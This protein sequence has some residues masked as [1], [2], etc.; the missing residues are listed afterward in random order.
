MEEMENEYEKGIYWVVFFLIIFFAAFLGYEFVFNNSNNKEKEKYKEVIEVQDYD[1]YLGV[2]QLFGD[3]DVPEYELSVEIID[4]ATVTFDFAVKDVVSFESETATFEDDIA[5]FELED[6]NEDKISGRLAFK[7]EKV[8][9]TITSSSFD[10]ITV[11]TIEFSEK[12][13]EELLIK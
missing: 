2:W 5:R 12:G 13:E 8:L 7:N 4:G 1:K 3:D 11:G 9:F 10:D 6:E